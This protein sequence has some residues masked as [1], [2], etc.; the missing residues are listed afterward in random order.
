MTDGVESTV[1]ETTMETDVNVRDVSTCMGS[2]AEVFDQQTSMEETDVVA[3]VLSAEE[4]PEE[5]VIAVES[6]IPLRQ[7]V[8]PLLHQNQRRNAQLA[9]IGASSPLP[10]DGFCRLEDVMSSTVADED[11]SYHTCNQLS[12]T[13]LGDDVAESRQIEHR[14]GELPFMPSPILAID[15]RDAITDTDDLE[16]FG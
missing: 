11:V 12:P 3:A 9:E 15:R 7:A 14:R 6:E 1:K 8:P 5:L 16:L 4:A 13:L 10:T 2:L